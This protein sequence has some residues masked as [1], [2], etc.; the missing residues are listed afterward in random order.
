MAHVGHTPGAGGPPTIHKR[1]VVRSVNQGT[2]RPRPNG[3]YGMKRIV[4][5]A[6]V[7][8]VALVL[9]ATPGF[10][11][12][13]VTGTASTDNTIVAVAVGNTASPARYRPGRRSQRARS[14]K[15]IAS[16]ITG[17]IGSTTLPGGQ[18][19]T[20]T[21]A[22]TSGKETITPGTQ[23]IP[24]LGNLT[25]AGG[26]IQSTVSASKVSSVV[27]FAAG[28]VDV[29][30]GLVG[31]CH[32][33]LQHQR[34]H[35][36]GRLL[37]AASP[38]DRR[39]QRREPRLLA[40]QPRDQPARHRVRRDRGRRSRSRY[41]RGRLRR[42][43]PARRGRHRHHGR[44]RRDRRHRDRDRHDSRRSSPRSAR[45]FRPA[46]ATRFSARS[47]HCSSTSTTSRPTLRTSAPPSSAP[48]TTCPVS[49]TGSSPASA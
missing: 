15:S 40:R 27:D 35:R 2:E 37:R 21:S 43:Q 5:F 9:I 16:L 46:P 4:G 44:P 3:G 25:V 22:S 24:G 41:R 29:L 19:R 10:A 30:G 20:A 14:V 48:W 39:R 1:Q 32:D 17:K 38:D 33:G 45:S 28:A 7:L 49:S 13:G 31:R 47:T 42:L 23:S 11:I 26:F 34:E 8:M 36:R 12:S 18:S 6:A